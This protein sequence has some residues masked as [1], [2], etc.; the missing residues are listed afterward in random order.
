[1]QR[2]DPRV[3]LLNAMG[4]TSASTESRAPAEVSNE[5]YRRTAALPVASKTYLHFKLC[6]MF[7]SVRNPIMRNLFY[8]AAKRDGYQKHNHSKR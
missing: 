2:T 8:E 5:R 4:T 6:M 1:M 3:P 7:K